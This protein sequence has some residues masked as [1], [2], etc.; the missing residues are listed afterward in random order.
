MRNTFLSPILVVTEWV[1]GAFLGLAILAASA[2]GYCTGAPVFD[3]GADESAAVVCD[4]RAWAD[5]ASVPAVSEPKVCEWVYMPRIIVEPRLGYLS[6]ANATI[7][8]ALDEGTTSAD[9]VATPP[10]LTQTITR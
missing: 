10:L 3:C 7:F 8:G 9:F 2:A 6:A 4:E 1:L 5:S